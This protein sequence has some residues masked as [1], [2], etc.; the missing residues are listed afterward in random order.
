VHPADAIGELQLAEADT[1]E[2]QQLKQTK[3]GWL[4]RLG[5]AM[6]D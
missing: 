4:A 3:L 1:I 5:L 2:E 6:Q